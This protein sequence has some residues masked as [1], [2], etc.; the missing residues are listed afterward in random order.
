MA[1]P[2]VMLSPESRTVPL[3]MVTTCRTLSPSRMA[4][5]GAMARIVMLLLIVS[6]VP[7]NVPSAS[8]KTV[9]LDALPTLVERSSVG[10]TMCSPGWSGGCGGG[11]SGGD[12][13]E[14]DDGVDGG[15]AG[16]GAP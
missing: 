12:G 11:G 14:G 15:P 16:G 13:G 8:T 6:V 4:A 5:P 9:P 7:A 10:H 2:F 3:E 1:L